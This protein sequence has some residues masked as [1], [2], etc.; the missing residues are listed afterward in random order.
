MEE[1]LRKSVSENPTLAAERSAASRSES[2]TSVDK[3]VSYLLSVVICSFTAS[4]FY[5]VLPF[6]LSYLTLGHQAGFPTENVWGL[7]RAFLG[8]VPYAPFA[9]PTVFKHRRQ[10]DNL[11]QLWC[12]PPV[13]SLDPPTDC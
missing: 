5:T 3:S 9:Q 10:L 7:E 4:V 6:L 12:S 13:F 8:Q 2:L 1:Q 11:I